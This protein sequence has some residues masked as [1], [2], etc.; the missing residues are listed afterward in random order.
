MENPNDDFIIGLV[1]GKIG[2]VMDRMDRERPELSPEAREAVVVRIGQQEVAIAL[3]SRPDLTAR[4]GA[5]A[6]E[7]FFRAIASEVR[8]LRGNAR[9]A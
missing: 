1:K 4:F 8:S 9:P 6:A 5:I 2:E 3:A 7:H